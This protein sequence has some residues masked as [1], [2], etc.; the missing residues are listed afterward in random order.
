MNQQRRRK[1]EQLVRKEKNHD[2][3]VFWKLNK[4]FKEVGDIN[5]VKYYRCKKMRNGNGCWHLTA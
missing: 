2:S 3:M 5:C 4:E 1:K